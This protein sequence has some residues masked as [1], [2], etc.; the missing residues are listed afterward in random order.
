MTSTELENLI[1]AGLPCEY[2]QVEGDGRHW[3]ATI[4]SPEFEG[5]SRIQRHQRV[6]KTLG[7]KMLTDEVHALSMHTVTPAEWAAMNED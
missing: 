7:A 2:I 6:Y 5:K 4:V 3:Q 1:S